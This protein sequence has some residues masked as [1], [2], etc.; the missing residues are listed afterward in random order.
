M[1]STKPAVQTASETSLRATVQQFRVHRVERDGSCFYSAIAL[2]LGKTS[3]AVRAEIAN[4][5][6]EHASNFV[7]FGVD[8]SALAREVEDL[9][10]N[11]AWADHVCLVAAADLY[12]RDI[13]VCDVDKHDPNVV[14]EYTVSWSAQQAAIQAASERKGAPDVEGDDDDKDIPM[15]TGRAKDQLHVLRI[16][17]NHYDFLERRLSQLS[18]GDLE[19]AL[20]E[21]IEGN[22]AAPSDEGASSAE[23]LAMQENQ[24]LMDQPGGLQ[25][26]KNLEA[27]YLESCAGHRNAV[28]QA[29]DKSTTT[30]YNNDQKTP[31]APAAEE[32]IKNNFNHTNKR[33]KEDKQKKKKKKK[34]QKEKTGNQGNPPEA[35]DPGH[36]VRIMENGLSTALCI[37]IVNDVV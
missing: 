31:T 21:V 20:L 27:N 17:N 5:I 29:A 18:G 2:V 32:N 35:R 25:Q 8:A 34:K 13:T 4:H 30:N 33:K 28:K 1:S 23:A 12:K 9:D 37:V 11:H 6:R 15:V 10:N 19:Q 3:R 26:Y 24:G 36:L 7:D 16:N 14:R 22:K